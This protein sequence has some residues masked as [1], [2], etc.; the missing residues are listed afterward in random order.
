MHSCIIISVEGCACVSCQ[1]LCGDR[2]C[3]LCN[4]QI[5][6][7]GTAGHQAPLYRL[8]AITEPVAWLLC[9]QAQIIRQVHPA[10]VTKHLIPFQSDILGYLWPLVAVV[11]HLLSA[12][13]RSRPHS[14]ADWTRGRCSSP[15]HAC[16]TSP[17]TASH[18]AL[19]LRNPVSKESTIEGVTIQ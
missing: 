9:Q 12:L 17:Q 5:L 11:L 15:E 14:F 16:Q 6:L 8:F 2:A 10:A 4:K 7:R 1:C 13:P 18:L 3:W 19:F